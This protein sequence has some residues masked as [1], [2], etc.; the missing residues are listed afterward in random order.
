MKHTFE[1]VCYLNDGKERCTCFD[2]GVDAVV[3]KLEKILKEQWPD[4][5]HCTCLAYAI[6]GL[7]NGFD[8]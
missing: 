4:T 7:K 3:R 2:K 8:R 5:H 6:D 1:H